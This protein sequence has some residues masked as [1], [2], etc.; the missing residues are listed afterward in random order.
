MMLEFAGFLLLTL[1]YVNTT[2]FFR[3]F[4]TKFEYVLVGKVVSSFFFK[5][6]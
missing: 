1:N 4:V 5:G 3:D 6:V 2:P